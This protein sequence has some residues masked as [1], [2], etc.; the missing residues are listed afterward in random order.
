[1]A[2]TLKI[3]I[4]NRV[5]EKILLNAR[6][7]IDNNIIV[8]DHPELDIFIMTAGSK[9]VALPKEQM[10]DE[11][12]D[13]QNRLFKFLTKK[14]VI[15]FSS[16]QSGNL[17]MSMEAT[18]PKSEEGDNIQYVLYAISNFVDQ[19]KPFYDNMEEFEQEM[20]NQMLE[21]EVDEYTEF[22]PEEYHS[23]VKGSLPPRFVRWGINNIYRI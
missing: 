1:M 20:E 7:T 10:D 21:P 3:K 12:Y 15:D 6:K 4:D 18:I 17:F 19:E 11:V 5:I 13:A 16:V 23:D 9:V 22:D 8:H 2:L 14:G